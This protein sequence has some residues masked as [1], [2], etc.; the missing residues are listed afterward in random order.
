[1][2]KNV[3]LIGLHPK[4]LVSDL[5]GNTGR[6]KTYSWSLTAAITLEFEIISVSVSSCPLL[7]LLNL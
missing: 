3:R 2:K 4:L 7:S 6:N 5:E 1:M